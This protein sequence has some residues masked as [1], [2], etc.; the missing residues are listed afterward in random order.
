MGALR[1]FAADGWVVF[2][3]TDPSG[4]DDVFAHRIGTDTT[5]K[6]A[7]TSASETMPAASPDARWV[8]YQSDVSGRAEVY[9]RPL[10]ATGREQQISTAGGTGPW[11][12]PSGREL[13]YVNGR[14]ELVEVQADSHGSPVGQPERVL[15]PLGD[16]IWARMVL[17][18]GQGFVMIRHRTTVVPGDLTLV[19]NWFEELKAKLSVK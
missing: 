19:R 17:P 13:Y 10:G 2:C 16:L 8:A 4:Q 1:G 12:S 15:F 7:A 6:V 5:I 11:W 14:S 18:G 9:I 3:E